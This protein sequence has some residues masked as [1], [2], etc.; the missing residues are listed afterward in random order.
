MNCGAANR[1]RAGFPGQIAETIS[2]RRP[3]ADE[4]TK[5]EDITMRYFRLVVCA[6][7]LLILSGAAGAQQDYINIYAGGGPNNVT[8][9]TAPVYGAT[10]VAVDGAGNVYYTSQGIATQHR[11][12]KI[13]KSTGILTIVAGTYGYGYSGD[14]GPAV[15][16]QLY[17]PAGVAVDSVGNLFIGDF[18]NCLVREVNASTGIITSIAGITTPNLS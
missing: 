13:T 3:G 8:A 18:N 7:I 6:G 16:A 17:T 2:I 11:V 14:G 4:R 10:N 1:M 9:T 12:W 5:R 15:N